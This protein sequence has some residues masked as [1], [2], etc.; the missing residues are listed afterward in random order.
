MLT[1]YTS[2]IIRISLLLTFL[3]SALDGCG[4][5]LRG[6]GGASV[7]LPATYIST[8]S[9]S[10]LAKDL[11]QALKNSGTPVVDHSS[12]A[13][14]ILNVLNERRDRRTLTVSA[15]GKVQEYQLHYLVQFN[16]KDKAG[17]SVLTDQS[18]RA[19][20]NYSYQ[21][22]AVLAKGGEEEQLYKDMQREAVQGIMRRLQT[23]NIKDEVTE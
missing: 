1:R 10:V 21:D 9:A 5:R 20:R 17:V 3:L 13:E 7:E 4:F 2:R 6:S 11:R 19:T 8:S 22:T 18:V 23:L 12:Q 15:R 14:L 16:V